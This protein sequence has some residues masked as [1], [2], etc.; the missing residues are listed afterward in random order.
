MTFDVLPVCW[1]WRWSFRVTPHSHRSIFT[2]ATSV[3]TTLVFR[4]A[5]VSITYSI[6]GLTIQNLCS[7]SL[8]VPC[9]HR[10]RPAPTSHSSSSIQLV[11]CLPHSQLWYRDC[12]PSWSTVPF[13]YFVLHSFIYYCSMIHI[14]YFICCP[15]RVLTNNSYAS[16]FQYYP[17][18]LKF[19]DYVFARFDTQYNVTW[20]Q[21]CSKVFFFHI[22]CY[23]THAGK[24]FITDPWRDPTFTSKFP[25]SPTQHLTLVLYNSSVTYFPVMFFS[26]KHLQTSFLTIHLYEITYRLKINYYRFMLAKLL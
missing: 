11:S 24:G 7:L 8:L 3:L 23:H 2:T 9:C 6:A 16:F 12:C 20:I 5:T 18:Y 14:S 26:R 19:A 4:I 22:F 15:A 10:V 13:I 25:V 17:P 21:H 1:F